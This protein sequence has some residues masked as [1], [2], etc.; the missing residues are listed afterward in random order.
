MSAN[1]NPLR[2]LKVAKPC[3][4]DWN[5]MTGNDRMRFCGQCQLNVYNLSG[6]TRTEAERLVTQAEGRVCARFYRRADGTVLTQDCPVGLRAV[7]QRVSRW[8]TAVFASVLGF[9]SG[10]GVVAGLGEKREP[11]YLM[12][13]MTIQAQ[14]EPAIMGDVAA[15]LTEFEQGK[16]VVMG[17]MPLPQRAPLKKR[18]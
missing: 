12:G 17:A 11:E 14:S 1:H 16:T 2:Q 18:R 15:P 7:K 6:M 10:V 9:F 5:A 4:A 13:Q 8:A 3:P